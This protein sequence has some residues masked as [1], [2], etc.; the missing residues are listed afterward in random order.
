MWPRGNIASFEHQD[1]VYDAVFS[2]DGAQILT[3]SGDR[4]ARLWDA[5]S[6]KLIVSFAH[7]DE[8]LR[9]A[10]SRTCAFCVFFERLLR[11]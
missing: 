2:P 10:F 1:S 4:T 6:G 7:Q 8:V 5:A 3:A 9:A 11:G